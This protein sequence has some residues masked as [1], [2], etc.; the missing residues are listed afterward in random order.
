M[1][2]RTFAIAAAT[3]IAVT[4]FGFS[5]PASAAPLSVA[6]QAFTQSLDSPV[7]TVGKKH[8]HKGKW[9]GHKRHGKWGGRGRHGK[10]GHKA[11]IYGGYPSPYYGGCYKQVQVLVGGYYA[12]HTINICH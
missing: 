11:F 7:I 3:A 9:G 5:A 2:T 4:A 8:G 10:W 12:W 6:S 1:N